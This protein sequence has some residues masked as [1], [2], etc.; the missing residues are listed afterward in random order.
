MEICYL[1][2][3][4]DSEA[5]ARQPT[6]QIKGLKD[7]PYF[8][9]I[10]IDVVTLGQETVLVEGHAVSVLCQ[11][12]DGRV[13]ILEARYNLRD[14]FAASVLADRIKI[15]EALQ[16]RY[17]PE[18]FRQNGLY[19]EYSTL[20]VLEAKP[21]PDKWIEKNSLAIANFI[22]SQREV[23]DTEEINEIL[24]SRTRYSAGELTL[25]D[26]EGAVI[27]APKADFDSDIALL[28]IGNYQILRYR[29]LDQ[30]I[31]EMLD[32]INERF[33]PKRGR[34]RPTRGLIRQIAE[35][36]LEVMIDFERAEQ[37]LLLIGDWY[38]AKLYEVIQ[39]EFYLKEWKESVRTK[40]DNLEN[41][42]ETMQENF[43]LSWEA[44]MERLQM[45]GWVLLLLG[46]L[47]LYI[48]DAGW[49]K[50]P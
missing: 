46:Y 44:L 34:P 2:A 14:P 24:S 6:E 45:L 48:L 20:L 10:D 30:S 32:K 27:I 22:R 43:S 21:A 42:V 15:Q 5:N 8:Q 31:E 26:W 19:E 33:F 36:R 4:P 50:F 28:K 25:V 9:P 16:S 49:V 35:H 3:F 12:Y 40:L 47:Y 39:K 13:Q 11:R 7:A 29:M 1:L 17:I 37:N 38:T 23:F 41:I 18:N